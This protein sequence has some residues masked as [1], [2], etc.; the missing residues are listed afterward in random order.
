MRFLS[1]NTDQ[2]DTNIPILV[3]TLT[4]PTGI[5]GFDTT[6][7]GHPVFELKDRYIIYLTNQITTVA[8]PYYKETLRP[9]INFDK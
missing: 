6:E 5:K 4:K 8:I 3:G 1:D 2:Q 7:V 9:H